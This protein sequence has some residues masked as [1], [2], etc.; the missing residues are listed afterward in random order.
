MVVLIIRMLTLGLLAVMLLLLRKLAQ[1]K[2][3]APNRWG[4]YVLLGWS[5]VWTIEQAWQHQRWGIDQL[6]PN[7]DELIRVSVALGICVC[8]YLGIVAIIWRKPNADPYS[9][10]IE[11]LGKPTE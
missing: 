5:S 4:L 11:D 9:A 8:L 10:K 2:G 7:W 6:M 1:K 3:L